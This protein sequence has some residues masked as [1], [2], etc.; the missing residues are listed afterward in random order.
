MNMV[1]VNPQMLECNFFLPSRSMAAAHPRWVFLNVWLLN[2]SFRKSM[3]HLLTVTL[4]YN[5][6]I[7]LFRISDGYNHIN[8]LCLLYCCHHKI[9][10][11]ELGPIH[12]FGLKWLGRGLRELRSGWVRFKPYPSLAFLLQFLSWMFY[13]SWHGTWSIH[14]KGGW[15]GCRRRIV[16]WRG[17][18]CCMIHAQMVLNSITDGAIL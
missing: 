10:Q 16:S 15:V 1:P 18:G 14:G 2:L 6:M 12:R 17:I 9:N 11:C 3:K 8:I 5:N 7:P 13:P 4:W